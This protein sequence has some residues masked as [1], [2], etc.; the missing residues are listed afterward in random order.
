MLISACKTLY[1]YL[2]LG[3]QNT[4][5]MTKEKSKCTW[6]TW[7]GFIKKKGLSMWLC[8]VTSNSS[9]YRYIILGIFL[10]LFVSIFLLYGF[11][12]DSHFLPPTPINP[13]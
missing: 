4:T 8:F 13:C 12:C 2:I 3:L 1:E 9:F 7:T 10:I 6:K 11:P 5:F